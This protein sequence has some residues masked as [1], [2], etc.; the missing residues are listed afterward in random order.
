M[1]RDRKEL[2]AQ[3]RK[4]CL[5]R[6]DHSIIWGT[7]DGCGREFCWVHH[8]TDKETECSEQFCPDCL[9][10]PAVEKEAPDAS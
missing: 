10:L 7:C 8:S 2:A 5:A 9:G 4:R 6:D 3:R 1:T